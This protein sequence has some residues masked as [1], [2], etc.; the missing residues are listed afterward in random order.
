MNNDDL[1][2]KNTAREINHEEFDALKD[3]KSKRE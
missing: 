3:N 2:R 1:F